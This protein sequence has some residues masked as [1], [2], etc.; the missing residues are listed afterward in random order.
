MLHHSAGMAG[1][2]WRE[3]VFVNNFERLQGMTEGILTSAR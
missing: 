3:K 1:I 2:S